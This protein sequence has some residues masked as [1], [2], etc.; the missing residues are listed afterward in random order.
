MKKSVSEII[1]SEEEIIKKLETYCAYR[2]RCESEVRQKMYQLN[3]G[4][5]EYD[6]YL[7]YLYENNY[8][9]EAR[10]ASAFANGKSNIKKWGRKKIEMELKARQVNTTYIK[11][12]IEQIDEGMY[13]LRL[14]DLLRKK[15]K[16]IKETDNYKKQQKLFQFA[17]Q[18][19]YESEIIKEAI[20]SIAE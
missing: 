1:L 18:K 11:R 5:E 14:E 4:V 7:Q 12:S 13:L 10:Y 2:E 8:L 3:I 9:N 17:L 6:H 15:I 16:T 19:G 20:K